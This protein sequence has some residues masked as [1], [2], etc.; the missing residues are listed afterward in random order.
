MKGL[1]GMETISSNF[2]SRSP[3]LDDSTELIVPM[4]QD[5][6]VHSILNSQSVS[7][8]P[9]SPTSS[10]EYNRDLLFQFEEEI[11]SSTNYETSREETD[12]S[13]VLQG[14]S[15]GTFKRNKITIAHVG[16]SKS[17]SSSVDG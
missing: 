9:L 13:E 17:V 8:L 7:S 4:T 3:S 12:Q 14:D 2:S 16:D 6:S 11:S 10:K 5:V 1:L 15:T